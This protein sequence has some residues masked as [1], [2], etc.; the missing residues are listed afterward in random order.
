MLSKKSVLAVL[1]GAAFG[2]GMAFLLRLPLI[3]L[4]WFLLGGAIAVVCHERLL[5]KSINLGSGTL[6][7]LASGFVMSLIVAA[8]TMVVAGIQTLEFT[9]AITTFPVIIC[10]LST[11]GGF[12]TAVCLRYLRT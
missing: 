10:L 6:V 5:P 12:L 3:G 9:V 11:V 8:T 2:T 4:L 7:G 1:L